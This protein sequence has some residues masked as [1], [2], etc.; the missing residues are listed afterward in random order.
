MENATEYRHIIGALQ[1]CTI[2]RPN[3]AFV[4]NQLCQFMHKPTIDYWSTAAKRVLHYLKGSIGHGLFF[5]KGSLTLN[6]FSDSDW[7][8]NLDDRRFTTGYAIFLGPYLISWSA[9]KQPV[10]FKS[11]IEA[12]YRSM[13]FA[14]A[15]LY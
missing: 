14:V 6:A 9:K 8:G 3:I 1:Y 15:E 2:T 11:R 12:E 4:V 5:G 13:A 10:V 7:A